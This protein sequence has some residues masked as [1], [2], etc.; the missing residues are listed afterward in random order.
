[1]KVLLADDDPGILDTTADILRMSGFDV[2]TVPDGK[3]AVRAVT[4]DRFDVIILDVMMPGLNGVDA[5]DEVRKCDPAA[6]FVIITAYSDSELVDDARKR[7]V[8]GVF[9]KPVDA[10]K[11]LARL[12][13]LRSDFVGG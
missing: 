4:D 11:L 9:F 6:K 7:G 3:A 1:M 2:T 12:E 8:D 10:S 13:L 5:I